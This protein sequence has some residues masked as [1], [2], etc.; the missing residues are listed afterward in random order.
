MA[1][2]IKDRSGMRGSF[3]VRGKED[4][5]VVFGTIRVAPRGGTFSNVSVSPTSIPQVKNSWP[6]V[7][8][9][10][11]RSEKSCDPV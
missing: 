9:L 4:C 10:R 3:E 11:S 8:L 2:T 7:Q 1:A 6:R 5:A